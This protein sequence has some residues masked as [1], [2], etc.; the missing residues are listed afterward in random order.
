MARGRF[1]QIVGNVGAVQIGADQQVG[2][3]VQ[4][5]AR[6]NRLS[7]RF[8]QGTVAMHFAVHFEVRHALMQQGQC[9]THL[10]S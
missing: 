9:F 3:A 6:K 10:Q 8:V 2:A 7:R 1:E 5:A 4:R